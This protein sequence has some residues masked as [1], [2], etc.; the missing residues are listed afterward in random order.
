MKP[1]DYSNERK[2]LI[3]PPKL[4]AVEIVISGFENCPF[5]L[6]I[7]FA[8]RIGWMEIISTYMETLGLDVDS[9]SSNGQTP[10]MCACEYKQLEIVTYLLQLGADPNAR[11][12]HD[13]TPLHYIFMNYIQDPIRA[14]Q[15]IDLLDRYGADKSLTNMWHRTP[16]WYKT[17]NTSHRNTLQFTSALQPVNSLFRSLA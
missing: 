7:W 9:K 8:A 5:I 6:S 11:D 4:N 13:N 1:K 12:I 16:T 17:G 10:L 3:R 15:I 2:A 14:Q